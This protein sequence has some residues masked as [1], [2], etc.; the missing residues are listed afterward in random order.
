MASLTV[1]PEGK[2]VIISYLPKP[3]LVHQTLVSG[4]GHGKALHHSPDHAWSLVSSSLHK[5]YAGLS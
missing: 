3:E 4:G 1:Y 2:L 5:R